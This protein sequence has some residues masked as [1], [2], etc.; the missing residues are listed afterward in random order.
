MLEEVA[1]AYGWPDP[2]DVAPTTTHSSAPHAHL[3]TGTYQLNAD[4]V[5]V[6]TQRQEQLW[7]RAPRQPPLLLAPLAEPTFRLGDLEGEVTFLKNGEGM[8]DALQ[9]QQDGQIRT[10]RKLTLSTNLSSG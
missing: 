2:N 10:A 7:L 5:L 6:I 3:Y 8:V 4:F 1:Q 9:L